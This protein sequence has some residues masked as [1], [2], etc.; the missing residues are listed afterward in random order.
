MCLLSSMCTSMQARQ[1]SMCL[2]VYRLCPRDKDVFIICSTRIL[3]EW[4]FR[5]KLKLLV[6]YSGTSNKGHSVLRTKYKKK[7][8]H[9][10]Q[11]S[12]PQMT[13]LLYFQCII[14]NSLKKDK[15]I[16]GPKVSFI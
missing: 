11:I 15:K 13:T 5:R 9:K 3:Q 8:L 7:P 2:H 16:A 14:N 1:Y 6:V 12:C 10:G 4:S